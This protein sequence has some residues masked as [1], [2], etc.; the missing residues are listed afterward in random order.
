M[1]GHRTPGMAEYSIRAGKLPSL[2]ID[3]SSQVS[4]G[5]RV[6]FVQHLRHSSEGVPENY[7]QVISDARR[8]ATEMST[9]GYAPN[10]DLTDIKIESFNLTRNIPTERSKTQMSPRQNQL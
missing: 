5:E 7:Q 1:A 6:T 2:Q 10:P 8:A 4:H 3:H 9:P